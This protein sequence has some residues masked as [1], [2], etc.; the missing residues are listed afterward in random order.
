MNVEKK[1]N[2]QTGKVASVLVRLYSW[3]NENRKYKSKNVDENIGH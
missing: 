3:D 1:F 2:N